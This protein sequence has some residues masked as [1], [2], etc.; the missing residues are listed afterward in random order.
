MQVIYI[1][2]EFF[3]NTLINYCILFASARICS[4]SARRRR[5]LAASALGG[6]Y[7]AAVWLP[8]L[9]FLRAP[10]VKLAV[11]AA[12]AVAAF[13]GETQLIRPV[14]VFFAVSAAFGGAAFAIALLT[15][16]RAADLRVLLPTL[17]L[18][19]AVFSAVF[20]RT[21]RRGG[22][23]R[24]LT[25]TRGGRAVRLD[26]MVDTGNSLT[27]PLTGC[28]VAV[29][30]AEDLMPLFAGETPNPAALVR[31]RGAV[32]AFEALG[33]R[34]FRLVPYSAVGVEGGLLLAFRPDEARLGGRR[35]TTLLV[36]V[37][38]NSVSDGGPYRALIGAGED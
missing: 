15:G 3:V 10:A 36:A 9:D 22:E 12:V 35:K 6:L 31:E 34:R 28:G 23:I 20:S 27:D 2:R 8:G 17:F 13:G 1:D 24:E 25:L 33:D 32:A 4:S 11:G 14:L 7:A 26:A 29:A 18:C 38:P 21:G 37:S 19:C 30:G 16:G 5:L